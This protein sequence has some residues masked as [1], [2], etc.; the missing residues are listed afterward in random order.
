VGFGFALLDGVV[1][2]GDLVVVIG[3]AR[4]GFDWLD[5]LVRISVVLVDGGIVSHTCSMYKGM[6]G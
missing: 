6:D 1:A 2:L 3:T 5:W 4:H